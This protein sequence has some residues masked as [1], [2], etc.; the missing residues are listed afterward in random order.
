MERL[1]VPESVVFTDVVSHQR[2]VQA[3]EVTNRGSGSAR[4]LVSVDPPFFLPTPEV[5]IASGGT[6]TVRIGVREAG[7]DPLSAYISLVGPYDRATV[8]VTATFDLDADDDGFLANQAGG[9]DC[10]DQ[11]SDVSPAAP[12]VCD[13][14]DN[15]CDGFVDVNAVD[16]GTWYRDGDGDDYGDAARVIVSCTA[17]SGYVPRKGD[18]NDNDAGVNPDATEIWYDGTDEDCD[19][20]SDYDR[21]RD[22]YDH[23]LYG[24]EDCRDNNAGVNPGAVEIWY[25]GVDQNCDGASDYDQDGD[26]Y[27]DAGHGGD[28]C[29]DLDGMVHPNAIEIDDGADDDCDGMIDETFL[30]RGDLIFT[31]IMVEPVAVSAEKGQYAEVL[32]VSERSIDLRGMTVETLWAWTTLE[33]VVLAP[34]DV[35][36]LCVDTEPSE[37]GGLSCDGP[38]PATLQA[39]DSVTLSAEVVLDEVN[40]TGWTLPSG[41]AL[42]LGSTVLDPD[43]ND[44]EANWCE[45]TEVFGSGDLGTP[46]TVSDPCAQ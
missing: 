19:G 26:S 24:G 15:D 39:A 10:D 30:S 46:G 36:L 37:N 7:Y 22:G 2:V 42:E 11:R 21:D 16:L 34:D 18:C 5:T 9:S 23:W 41:A 13:G 44:I 43:A 40:W 12:E 27:D 29:D 25:D 20:R 28:D 45:A 31:E 14:L 1:E 17:P 3:F 33:S 8:R 6:A 35:A 38:L 4:I 32:N